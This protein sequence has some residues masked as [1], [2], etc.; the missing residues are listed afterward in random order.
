MRPVRLFEQPW[1]ART[2][3]ATRASRWDG[4][5][6]TGGTER[7]ALSDEPER[8]GRGAMNGSARYV[9]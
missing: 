9:E 5:Q 6:G 8:A 3:F 7:R 2:A 1:P 4:G